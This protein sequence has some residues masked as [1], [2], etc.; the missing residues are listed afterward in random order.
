M[1]VGQQNRDGGLL[2]EDIVEEFESRSDDLVVGGLQALH[3][4]V[5]EG[6]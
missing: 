5:D 6:G 4:H 3:H 1:F 2:E